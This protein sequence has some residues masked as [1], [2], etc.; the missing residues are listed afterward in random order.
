VVKVVH[1]YRTPCTF[2]FP[3]PLGVVE[4]ELHSINTWAGFLDLILSAHYLY[5]LSPL[6]TSSFSGSHTAF[7]AEESEFM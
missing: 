1:V 6:G 3:I 4:N 5:F 2:Q 7:E